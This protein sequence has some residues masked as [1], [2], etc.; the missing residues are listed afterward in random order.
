MKNKKYKKKLMRALVWGII[1][2]ISCLLV[3]LVHEWFVLLTVIS[4]IG[5]VFELDSIGKIKDE[6]GPE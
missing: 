3:M 2:F 6:R 5:L 1:L 4:S